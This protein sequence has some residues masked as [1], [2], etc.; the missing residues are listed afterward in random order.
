M[1]DHFGHST[2]R[3][4]HCRRKSI[5][6]L[7]ERSRSF[8]ILS[9]SLFPLSS[10]FPFSLSLSLSLSLIL[11][12]RVQ[13]APSSPTTPDAVLANIP[14]LHASHSRTFNILFSQHHDRQDSGDESVTS[15]QGTD[16]AHLRSEMPRRSPR[17]DKGG[18]RRRVKRF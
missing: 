15:I 16:A 17:L 3:C 5:V 10:L 9:H 7:S 12:R 11:V 2:H 18:Q 13:R 1:I 8:H 14:R 4:F 6:R